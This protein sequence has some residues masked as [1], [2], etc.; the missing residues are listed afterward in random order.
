MM[1]YLSSEYYN[2]PPLFELYLLSHML[3]LV[4]C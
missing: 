2:P 4:Q 3:L 1:H